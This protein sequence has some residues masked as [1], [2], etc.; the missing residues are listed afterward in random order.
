[1]VF[2]PFGLEKRLKTERGIGKTTT[3]ADRFAGNIAT[4]IDLTAFDAV[5]NM[6]QSLLIIVDLV[7]SIVVEPEYREKEDAPTGES[8]DEYLK[9]NRN[10]EENK[11]DAHPPDG[12]S[13]RER[14]AVVICLLL[15]LRRFFSRGVLCD[16]LAF[17]S[18]DAFRGD[19]LGNAFS[20][21]LRGRRFCLGGLLGS[22]GLAWI[23]LVFSRNQLNDC[24]FSGISDTCT[25]LVDT[26]VSTRT[27]AEHARFLTEKEADRFLVPYPTHCKAL[28]METTLGGSPFSL[29]GQG[30]NLLNKRTKSFGLG[31]GCLDTAVPEER[32]SQIT[33]HG[34]SVLFFPAQ[35]VAVF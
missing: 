28:E 10:H 20:L 21:G 12:A 24:H 9:G 15:L 3:G 23:A 5:V 13:F 35:L 31:Q 4:G 7:P 17:L 34:L 2:F 8:N 11:K 33:H 16:R 6:P 22:L 32:G 30:D 1:M 27:V 25:Q 18:R 14:L 29:L 26:R 19:F